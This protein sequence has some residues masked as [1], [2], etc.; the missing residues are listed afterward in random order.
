[1]NKFLSLLFLLSVSLLCH[2]HGGG[3]YEHSDK[4]GRAHV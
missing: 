2:A 4:I 1:M 3:N